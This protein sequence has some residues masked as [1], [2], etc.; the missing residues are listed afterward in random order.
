MQRGI[1]GM[2]SGIPLT[3]PVRGAGLTDFHFHDLRHTYA[4]WLMMWEVPLATVRNLLGH[5]S[6]TMTLRYAHLS[7]KHPPS[8]VR[9]LDPVSVT[10]QSPLGKHDSAIQISPVFENVMV[11]LL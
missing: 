11:K 6:P 10:S 8:A 1:G 4:S 7:L 5:T 9:V 3:R 2:T